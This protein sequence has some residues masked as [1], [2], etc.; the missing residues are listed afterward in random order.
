MGEGIP[1]PDN[2]ISYGN[3][4]THPGGP[5]G[6]D[7]VPAW[8]TEGEF[9]NNE[10]SANLFA[11][12]LEQMNEVGKKIQFLKERGY[13]EE[14]AR[15]ILGFPANGT[16]SGGLQQ[17]AQHMPGMSPQGEPTDNVKRIMHKDRYGNQIEVEFDTQMEM[18]AGVPPMM[19]GSLN[20]N[21][22]G[23]VHGAP[24][25]DHMSDYNMHSNHLLAPQ[26]QY[27]GWGGKILQWLLPSKE[28][29]VRP[30]VVQP[31]RPGA[32]L[33]GGGID[34]GDIG[35]VGGWFGIDLVNADPQCLCFR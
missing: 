35:N 34:T 24:H 5:R 23:S 1:K 14:Q 4:M 16:A 30:E 13:S 22:G 6:T 8:L 29:R 11:P 15:Q 10:E 25:P 18:D 21:R 12:E 19:P 33:Q 20:L 17:M 3:P 7:T 27:Y 9:V 31:Q 28:E 26:A 32:A 2:G